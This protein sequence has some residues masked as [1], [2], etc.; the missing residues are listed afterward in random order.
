M[1]CSLA[2]RSLR[3]PCDPHVKYI[4]EET[5]DDLSQ[6]TSTTLNRLPHHAHEYVCSDSRRR[7]IEKRLEN[8]SLKFSVK[9]LRP[10]RCL[11]C[12][13]TRRNINLQSNHQHRAQ[14]TSN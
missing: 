10:T 14:R 2:D 8:N 11:V 4:E 7:L 3:F 13:K 1:F 5:T 6:V 9:A 12:S